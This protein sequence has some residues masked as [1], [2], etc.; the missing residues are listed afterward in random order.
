MSEITTFIQS[1]EQ[2]IVE[3]GW[4][5]TRF[6]KEMANDP[7]FVF[8]IRG[9]REP[10]SAVRGRVLQRMR[11]VSERGTQNLSSDTPRKAAS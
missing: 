1:V 6:G 2:F 7:R 4:S 9:G 8:Q 11:A 10:R 5:A 3:H